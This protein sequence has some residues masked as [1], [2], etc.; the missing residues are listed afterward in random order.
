[1][2]GIAGAV[3]YISPAVLNAVPAMS[4]AI[5]H[6]G[7]DGD[8]TWCSLAD[9]NQSDHGALLAHRRLAIIDLSPDGAQPMHDPATGNVIVFNGEIYNYLDIKPELEK[10]GHTFHSKS[11]T[12][13]LLKAYAAWGPQCVSRLRGMFTFVIWDRKNS[14]AFI[15]RDRVGIKPLYYATVTHSSGKTT[16]LFA[17]EVRALLASNLI[18]RHLN[19]AA[20]RSFLWNGFVAGDQSIVENV[21]LLPAGSTLSV[22]LKGRASEPHTYWSIPEASETGTAKQLEDELLASVRLRL[23]SD[24]P[25]GIFLSGGVDSSAVAALA[26]RASSSPIKTFNISFDESDFDESRYAR[27]VADQLGTHHTELRLTQSLFASQLPDALNSI[28]QPTFDAINTYFVSRAVREAGLTVALAG[29]G[30]DELFAGYKSF[31]DIPKAR[32]LGRFLAPLPRSLRRALAR[33]IM[34]F[35]APNRAAI[36]PQTRWGKLHDLFESAADLVNLYQVSYS[37]FTSR[38]QSQLARDLPTSSINHGLPSAYHAA[39]EKLVAHSPLLHAISTLELSNFITQRLLRDTDS[40]SMAVALEARVPLLDHE[41]IARAASLPPQ[42]RFYPLGR[43]QILRE[44]C[45]RDLDPAIFDRPKSGFVLPLEV[46][47][48]AQLRDQVRATLLDESLC[49]TVGLNPSAVADLWAAFDAGAPG[50]YWSRLW[51]IYILLW[52]CRT[53]NMSLPA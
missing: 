27:A 29:T 30:G 45:L 47:C 9:P 12:E 33:P 19:P 11:D 3:G 13:V 6:R 40:S 7:P 44:T 25:L 5:A 34:A 16:F 37:L 36:P 51:A 14:F 43:K 21:N 17:S 1:M 52:W 53:H 35:K 32:G 4:A 31:V 8:G 23:I 24:V 46:W 18:P 39:L 38:F 15:A 48:R 50:I 10:L 20:I 49:R 28:D 42:Q 41:V 2:C 26:V 22:S